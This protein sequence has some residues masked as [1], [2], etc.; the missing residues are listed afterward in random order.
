MANLGY[1]GFIFLQELGKLLGKLKMKGK[2]IPQELG[3][4]HL[5]KPCSAWCVLTL[6]FPE[7]SFP[8]SFVIHK[9]ADVFYL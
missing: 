3:F 1:D 6:V 7:P 9:H 4:L 5:E 2:L 8:L